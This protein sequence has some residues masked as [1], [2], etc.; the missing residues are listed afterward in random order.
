[1]ASCLLGVLCFGYGARPRRGAEARPA[2]LHV[3]PDKCDVL[4][5]TQRARHEPPLPWVSAMCRHD[6][7]AALAMPPP[8]LSS[9]SPFPGHIPAGPPVRPSPLLQPRNDLAP[10]TT[11]RL[12]SAHNGV[13]D[14]SI[15]VVLYGL[16]ELQACRCAR[17]HQPANITEQ[18]VGVTLS[19][20]LRSGFLP[21]QIRMWTTGRAKRDQAAFRG[22][23]C[24]GFMVS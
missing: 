23:S 19:S 7:G 11:A 4:P 8:P 24:C 2:S 21:F 17:S 15:P 5:P 20:G 3:Q 9:P 1:M 18:L 22:R 6:A 13:S 10:G 14:F 16:V 12:G